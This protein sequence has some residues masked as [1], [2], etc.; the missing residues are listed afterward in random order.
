MELPLAIVTLETIRPEDNGA[1][2]EQKKR[3]SGRLDMP[4]GKSPRQGQNPLLDEWRKQWRIQQLPDGGR[5]FV[6]RI[7]THHSWHLYALEASNDAFWTIFR[8][9]YGLFG[10]LNG[11]GGR[12]LDP[13]LGK[14]SQQPTM[15]YHLTL[16][17]SSVYN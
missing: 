2:F 3:V 7:S 5:R 14:H 1:A 4:G 17:S 8:P 16:T 11:G 12:P 9:K 6:P 13:P 10:N 15:P